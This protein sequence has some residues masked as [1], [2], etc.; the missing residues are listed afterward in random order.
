MTNFFTTSRHLTK[1]GNPTPHWDILDYLGQVVTRCVS[2]CQA[3]NLL[4]TLNFTQRP[5][6][7]SQQPEPSN[8]CQQVQPSV[9]IVNFEPSSCDGVS[10]TATNGSLVP[11][12]SV[13]LE[14]SR[15]TVRDR[16]DEKIQRARG[17]IE[18]SREEDQTV[19]L[20]VPRLFQ[21]LAQDLA[22][23]TRDIGRISEEL[24]ELSREQRELSRESSRIAKTAIALAN[25]TINA[26]ASFAGIDLGDADTR[27]S[28][29]I[30]RIACLDPET[31]DV[32][33]V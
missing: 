27:G 28:T 26:T 31:I 7:E 33:V 16:Y 24:R 3:L 1:T 32:S 15:S 11:N 21:N 29:T 4:K 30:D 6:N 20:P 10:S 18:S 14:G 5:T 23:G 17:V 13:S 8:Q 12:G 19:S 9:E 22:D 2:R 25:F